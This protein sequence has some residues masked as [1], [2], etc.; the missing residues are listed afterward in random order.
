MFQIAF[1]KK[2]VLKSVPNSFPQKSVLNTDRKSA[3]N[4]IPFRKIHPKKG[5]KL[6]SAIRSPCKLRYSLHEKSLRVPREARSDVWRSGREG[7]VRELLECFLPTLT[8]TPDFPGTLLGTVG[9]PGTLFRNAF[10]ERFLNPPYKAPTRKKNSGKS[11]RKSVPHLGAR[12]KAFRKSVP[13]L[14]ARGKAFGKS[15]PDLGTWGKAFRKRVPDRGA[16][17]PK[18]SEKAFWVWVRGEVPLTAQMK[19]S[20]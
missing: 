6:C 4:R 18:R 15:V 17:G 1:Q 9:I 16:R 2:S 8:E 3:P 10:L 20:H 5:S 7:S 19:K 13:D 11:F 12:G 14:G